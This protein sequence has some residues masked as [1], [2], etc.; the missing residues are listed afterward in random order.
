MNAKRSRM[1]LI[2]C[3]GKLYA[4]GGYDGAAN[5]NSVEMYDPDKDQWTTIA[6]MNSHEGVVGVGVLPFEIDSITSNN[7]GSCASN[8]NQNL[9]NLIFNSI[10][11]KLAQESCQGNCN[12]STNPFAPMKAPNLIN[13][14]YSLME[15][16]EE[17]N[18]IISSNTLQAHNQPAQQTNSQNS[19][20]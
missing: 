6:S 12:G 15:E 16:E 1:A 10:K 11:N 14:Y 5:L 4:I 8:Q 13:N 7:P 9:E 17:E 19:R 2:T 3:N 20:N 18:T